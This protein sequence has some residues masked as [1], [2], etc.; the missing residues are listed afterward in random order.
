MLGGVYGAQV[1]DGEGEG[2]EGEE[3]DPSGYGEE[4]SEEEGEGRSG[5]AAYADSSV[6][7]AGYGGGI[8]DEEEDTKPEP[9]G[10]GDVLEEDDEELEAPRAQPLRDSNKQAKSKKENLKQS[11]YVPPLPLFARSADPSSDE[12]KKPVGAPDH[13]AYGPVPHPH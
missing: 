8:S 7:E 6:V 3:M 4:L 9:D 10:Y 12:K 11:R 5:G 2:E 13:E 1:S